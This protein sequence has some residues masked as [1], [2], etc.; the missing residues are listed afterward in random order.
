MTY[1]NLF[2]LFV[3]A[4]MLLHISAHLSLFLIKYMRLLSTRDG[5]LDQAC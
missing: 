3:S 4:T 1:A 5:L 2:H